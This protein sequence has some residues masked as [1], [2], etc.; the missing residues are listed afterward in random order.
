MEKKGLS[1]IVVTVLV[2]LGSLVAVGIIWA[3]IGPVFQR[4]GEIYRLQLACTGLG[5]EPQRCL[6]KPGQGD[7][8]LNLIEVIVSST[9]GTVESL[10]ATIEYDDATFETKE[11]SNVSIEPL[12]SEL[13][14]FTNSSESLRA[15]RARVAAAI[16]SSSGEIIPCQESSVTVMCGT[17]VGGSGSGTGCTSDNDCSSSNMRCINGVC[18]VFEDRECYNDND[19]SPGYYCN[20]NGYCRREQSG[21]PGGDDDDDGGCDDSDGDGY[22]AES[23]GGYDCDDG[24]DNINPGEDEICNNGKDDDCD[25]EIDMDDDECDPGCPDSDGDGYQSASCGGSDCNDTNSNIN[26]GV[27][28][29]CGNGID[30]DCDDLIDGNDPECAGSTCQD[31]DGDGYGLP[32]NPSCPKGG[33]ED[34]NDDNEFEH[35]DQEWFIDKDED[36]YAQNSI[37]TVISC[38]QPDILYDLPSEQKLGIDCDDY[39]KEIHPSATEICNLRNDD[40]DSDVDE[41]SCPINPPGSDC[42]EENARTCSVGPPDYTYKQYYPAR[43]K[44]NPPDTYCYIKSGP[45][46]EGGIGS[47]CQQ[48]GCGQGFSRVREGDPDCHAQYTFDHFCC[49]LID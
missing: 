17:G 3:F 10:I 27:P 4:S 5:V 43:S 7:G 24:D 30:D 47:E 13:V 18:T 26:S 49:K 42:K 44:C 31:G 11:V 6:V 21:D 12:E 35:P 38:Q 39:T 28:E 20:S 36:Y 33:E 8:N 15:V 45:R 19:C 16:R 9:E 40:C 37:N 14:S 34:C 48:A 23:C 25:G 22:G 41:G 46:C 29:N 1:S 32:G 2:I